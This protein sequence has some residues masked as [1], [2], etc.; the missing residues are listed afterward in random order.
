MRLMNNCVRLPQNW[1]W[2][3]VNRRWSDRGFD[4][5]DGDVLISKKAGSILFVA[6]GDFWD[7]HM[8]N[9]TRAFIPIIITEPLVLMREE[10]K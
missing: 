8:F 4:P 2:L 7:I 9:H 6:E 10:V 5:G 1:I 3:V